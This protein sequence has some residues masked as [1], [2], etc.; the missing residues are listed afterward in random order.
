MAL[1]VQL[2][3]RKVQ[4]R[5]DGFYITVYNRILV[6][7]VVRIPALTRPPFRGFQGV[8]GWILVADDCL[9]VNPAFAT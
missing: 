7:S 6:V 3:E 4:K 8:F 1:S 2:L 9:G 5:D